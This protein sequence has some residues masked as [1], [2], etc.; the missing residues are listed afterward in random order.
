MPEGFSLGEGTPSDLSDMMTIVLLG[1]TD[2][3]MWKPMT[4]NV[5][6]E[7]QHEYLTRHFGKRFSLPGYPFVVVREN[8][9]GK[10]V[11][12][13]SL[14]YPAVRSPEHKELEEARAADTEG[15]VAEVSE[16]YGQ[17]IAATKD[18]GYDPEKHFHRKGTFVHPDYQKRGFGTWVT[19]ACNDIADRE[20]IATYVGA[21]PSSIKLFRQT[22]F[23]VIGEK[24]FDMRPWGG[25]EDGGRNWFLVREPAVGR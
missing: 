22:G 24:H 8:E 6:F 20:G 23:K 10:V 14:R 15:M 2:D 16:L 12:W 4:R 17:V 1:W 9:S 7:A 11:A 18:L 19:Q 21:R 5:S 25:T 3:G 13:T